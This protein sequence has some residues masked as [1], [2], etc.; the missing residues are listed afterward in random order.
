MD[1]S[2][3][4]R[5]LIYAEIFLT[6]VAVLIIE[7]LAVRM[8]APFFG[9]TVYT[10]SSVISVVLAALS[11]GY[12]LGGHMADRYPSPQWF[13]R[14]ILASGVSTLV[15][16]LSAEPLLSLISGQLGM[17]WGPLLSSL[18]LF[19]VAPALLGML[20]P[21]AV[22]LERRHDESLG[23]GSASGNVF[24]VS[25]VGSIVGGV[26]TGFVLIPWLSVP[27]ILV[28]TG[29]VLV[30]MGLRGAMIGWPS[31]IVW[32]GLSIF[33]ATAT[34]TGAMEFQSEA[35]LHEEDSA[36]SHI[37]VYK[38]L[39]DGEPVRI[40][41]R[42]RSVSGAQDPKDPQ[43]LV[44][45]YSQYSRLSALRQE[46]PEQVLVLGTAAT[47][48]IPRFYLE[49]YPEAEVDAV[50]IDPALKE[51]SKQYFQYPDSERLN[52]IVDDGRRH[53]RQTDKR[54]D[55]IYIDAFSGVWAPPAHMT[56]REFFQQVQNRL[57]E[58]GMVITNVIGSLAQ[59]EQSL[60]FSMARTFEAVFD[61]TAYYPESPWDRGVQNVQ[62]AA[63][64]TPSI[65]WQP[66]EASARLA[67]LT[68][69]LMHF[70]GDFLSRYTLLEDH[71][72]PSNYLAS[73][74]FSLEEGDAD[75]ASE[76]G[77]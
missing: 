52:F 58:D 60:L 26:V 63:S 59:R 67:S 56:T 71:Y 20:S 37:T 62:F 76:K 29:M 24:F 69:T 22:V 10:T 1:S 49:R 48:S 53:L 42:N 14:I 25:T 70:N 66:P 28:V 31:R 44:L 8:L 34:A 17:I 5:K 54:Y 38:G 41:S 16:A 73:L 65:N 32:T 75:S 21:Y 40:F 3:L 74:N 18:I 15:L 6:G 35:L 77:K 4:Q 23:T 12:Y 36:Y 47:F 61:H 72:A 19:A 68:K 64:M 57:S 50:D 27:V 11:L 39:Y 2:S 45:D 55:L 33:L 30:M 43:R 9:T 46:P 13:Y 51:V 7:V